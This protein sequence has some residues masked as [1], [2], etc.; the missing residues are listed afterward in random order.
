[1]ENQPI[2]YLVN[3]YSAIHKQDLAKKMGLQYYEL[4]KILNI[5]LIEML[6]KETGY[7]KHN[8]KINSPQLWIIERQTGWLQDNT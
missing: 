5:D 8:R 3:M 1:M 2:K 6:K 4:R 7:K